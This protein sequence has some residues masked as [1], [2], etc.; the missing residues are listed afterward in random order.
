MRVECGLQAEGDLQSGKEPSPHPVRRA[1]DE[2]LVWMR[3]F[4]TGQQ[5]S[6]VS[7]AAL[8]PLPPCRW[9]WRGVQHG[10]WHTG[11]KIAPAKK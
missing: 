7:L 2:A 11:H 10:H 5:A 9:N 4:V 3:T 1:M 8:P 6:Q